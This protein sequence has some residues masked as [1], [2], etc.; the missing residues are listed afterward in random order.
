MA[1]FYTSC[2]TGTGKST[3]LLKGL[4]KLQLSPCNV[5]LID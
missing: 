4:M 2:T 5:Y 3:W 1:D